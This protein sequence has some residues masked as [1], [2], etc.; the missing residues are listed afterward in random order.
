MDG[1]SSTRRATGRIFMKGFL[2]AWASFSADLNLVIRIAMGVALLGGTLL[3]RAKR[4]TA[5]GICQAAVLILN[6]PMIA[7]VMWPSLRSRVLPKLSSHFGK[8]YYASA[9]TPCCLPDEPII[10]G[11]IVAIDQSGRS[12]QAINAG[13]VTHRRVSGCGNDALNSDASRTVNDSV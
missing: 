3:A 13:C 2:G 7:L 12:A 1:G 8:R 10:D 4:Y 5:H 6:V 9:A 11:E